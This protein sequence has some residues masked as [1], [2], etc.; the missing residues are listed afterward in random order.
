MFLYNNIW[1]NLGWFTHFCANI[2]IITLFFGKIPIYVGLSLKAP[3]KFP[4]SDVQFG[5]FS[6]FVYICDS[7]RKR[8]E[9]KEK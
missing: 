3:R 2:Y 1:V 6:F 4:K 5:F 8:K 9:A 7:Y